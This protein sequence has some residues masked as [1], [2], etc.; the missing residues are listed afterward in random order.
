[1][2]NIWTKLDKPIMALAP[3][4][5]VTDSAFRQIIARRGKPDLF[6]TEFV[7]ADGLTHKE[8][9]FKLGRELH[10]T[11]TEK[12]LIAQ[13]FSAN[14]EAMEKA[15]A[16]VSGLG[17]DGIDINMG[18]PDRAVCRQGAGASLIKNPRLAQELIASARS[19]AGDLP[20]SVKTRIGD[21]RIDLETWPEA[22][23]EAKPAAITFH[24]R[25][26][27]EM[28]KVEAHWELVDDLMKTV[29]GSETLILANGDVSDLSE[30][31][32]KSEAH[33][34]DGIMIGRA[35]FGD[36][37]FFS[38]L[39]PQGIRDRLEALLEHIDVFSE[40]Y[41]PGSVNQELFGGHVKNW[42]VMKKHIKAYVSGFAGA[43]DLRQNLMD[44]A[45]PKEAEEL[46]RR[47]LNSSG[48]ETKSFKTE[49]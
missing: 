10:Y 5:D 6:F 21:T 38:R 45:G 35:I 41:L 40:M 11:P 4:A 39:K 17:F 29:A 28:S 8:A 44:T 15:A 9:H 3:M 20:V 36:P 32:E 19:G 12:P 42:A 2:T 31:K 24:L 13:L 27:S 22:L 25:T 49:E 16:V 14:P 48:S 7:S 18:C 1:M 30:A 26:R 47:Y 43:A 34:L 23:L 46:I 37:W 33:G